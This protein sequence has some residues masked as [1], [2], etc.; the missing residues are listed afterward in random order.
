VL[1]GLLALPLLSKLAHFDVR[2]EM[3]V[4]LEGDQRNLESYEK[5][6]QILAEVEVVVV[7]MEVEEVFSSA[8]ID[9]VRRV[10]EA[11]NRGEGVVDV[12]SLTHSVKPVRRGLSFE[13]VPFVPAGS[14]SETE[15]R[16]LKEFSLNHPLVRNLMVSGDSRHTLIMVTYRRDLSSPPEQRALGREIDS[17]LEPFRREGLRFQV[18]A[19]PLVEEEVR[20]ALRSDVRLMLPLALLL[21]VVI[22]WVTFRSWRYLILILLNQGIVLL[23]LPGAI[24]MAGFSLTVFSVMLLPLLTGIHLTLLVHVYSSLQRALRTGEVGGAV[25]RM[26]GEVFK[27]CT[28]AAITTAAGL[29]SL[30]WSEVRQVR[31]F[32]IMGVIGLGLIFFLTFGPGLAA[33]KVV[34][35]FLRVRPGTRQDQSRGGG[36]DA[37]WAS[38]LARWVNGRRKA[39]ICFACLAVGV[40][41]IGIGRVRTDIRAVEFLGEASPTRQAVE[42]MDRVYGGIN[43]VQIELDSGVENGVNQEGYLRYVASLQEYVEGRPEVSA[44]YSYAQLMAMMNQIWEGGGASALELPRQPWLLQLFV[45]ALQTQNYPFLTALADKA[46]RTGYL[47]MRTRDM[48]A[49]RYLD[50]LNEVVAYAQS[51]KPDGVSVS[52]AKGIHSILEADRRIVRSQVRTVVVTVVV[53]GLVLALLWRSPV[54]ALVSLITNAIPVGLV[55]A[56]AGF[57]GVALNSITVM[58]GAVALGI[59]VD[60]SVHFITHWREERLRGARDL[61]AME[62]ALR[63]KGRPIVVSSAALIAIFSLFACSSFPPVVAFGVLCAVAFLGALLS[64][65]VLLPSLLPNREK[66]TD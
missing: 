48:P 17:A 7:S 22:L 18:L 6:H 26:L 11:L 35:G 47:V 19:L 21:L 39:V 3:R 57:S 15:L 45:V 13:M 38:V 66:V 52:A 16:E 64:V 1:T 59:A 4:L 58:V 51:T 63:V 28:F 36:Q 30:V 10:S 2:S 8:G 50:L 61:A 56:V 24:Q 49:Q 29:G 9:A 40:G 20:G 12:K 32:G 34:G 62:S 33:L 27:A 65:L 60:D 25:E 41:V 5:V 53:V 42:E 46:F 54:L 31:E 37:R 44:V 23:L 14:L 55:I 43:V